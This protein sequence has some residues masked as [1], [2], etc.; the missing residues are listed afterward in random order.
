VGVYGLDG[1]KT[2][3]LEKDAAKASSQSK[4]KRY[5]STVIVRRLG[6]AQAP[7]DVLIRFDNGET[8]VEQWDGKYRWVKYVYEKASRVKSAEVDPLR[9][10]VL[11]ANFT[12]NS[13]TV[14]EDNRGA[15]KW[16]VRWIFW[17]E[18]L[19][20]AAGFFS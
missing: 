8:V 10:L 17:V 16:Y 11:D 6:E 5:R 14:Q 2:T 1:N 13:Y 4:G 20:F 9:K 15:A 12:N 18:N 7:V 19:F 3:I